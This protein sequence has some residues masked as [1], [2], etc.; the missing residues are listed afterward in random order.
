MENAQNHTFNLNLNITM[1]PCCQAGGTR[2]INL[3]LPAEDPKSAPEIIEHTDDVVLKDY[4]TV[5]QVGKVLGKS[6]QATYIF[7]QRRGAHL[8]RMGDFIVMHKDEM[9]KLQ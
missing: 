3:K 6:R 4:L 7:M 2:A 1:P 9:P 5:S 8:I